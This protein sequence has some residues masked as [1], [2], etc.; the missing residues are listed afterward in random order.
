M[1]FHKCFKKIAHQ[2][3]NFLDNTNHALIFELL[4][5]A[6]V[7]EVEHVCRACESNPTA[8]ADAGVYPFIVGDCAAN[9]VE[10]YKYMLAIV[11]L[12]KEW[13]GLC[14][15]PTQE[16]AVKFVQM[17]EL[18]PT[19]MAIPPECTQMHQICVSI[20]EYIKAA[21][22]VVTLGARQDATL[23]P[24]D[25]YEHKFCFIDTKLAKEIAADAALT[26]CATELGSGF[27]T[28]VLS[29]ALAWLDILGDRHRLSEKVFNIISLNRNAARRTGTHVAT[30]TRVAATIRQW[31][32]PS[33][34]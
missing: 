24:G 1:A 30:D 8:F 26:A 17:A 34:H 33:L 5:G 21:R 13:L 10:E 2:H 20:P 15:T 11:E 25:L 12:E 16:K 6:A 27:S 19:D 9:T 22:Q 18:V 23:E 32:A 7:S 14:K 31:S 28:E 4:G 3:R 29:R